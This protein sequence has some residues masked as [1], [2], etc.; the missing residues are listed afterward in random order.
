MSANYNNNSS[1]GT[2]AAAV[3]ASGLIP[4]SPQST[5]TP[6]TTMASPPYLNI[7]TF[8]TYIEVLA[9][10]EA[11]DETKLKGAQEISNNFEVIF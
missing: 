8:Q 9:D 3:V 6:T 11:T 5:P 4:S 1:S 7:Q 10:K 2:A